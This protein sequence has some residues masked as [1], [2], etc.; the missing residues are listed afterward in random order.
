[1]PEK[2]EQASHLHLIQY[3]HRFPFLV[4][5][6]RCQ[7]F[8]V[9]P[10]LQTRSIKL[11]SPRWRSSS[12]TQAHTNPNRS[13]IHHERRHEPLKQASSAAE[14]DDLPV[15]HDSH[16]EIRSYSAS[17]RRLTPIY[18]HSGRSAPPEPR[19]ALARPPLGRGRA[20]P[21]PIPKRAVPG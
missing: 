3:H 19:P 1:M 13:S 21:G 2:W 6:S 12:I 17:Q 7:P 8:E 9:K 11:T 4:T 18:V 16:T 10:P 20:W 15:L 5:R 14:L